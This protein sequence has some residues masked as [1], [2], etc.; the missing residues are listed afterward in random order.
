MPKKVANTFTGRAVRLNDTFL[1]EPSEWNGIF[2]SSAAPD[3]PFQACVCYSPTEGISLDYVIEGSSNLPPSSCLHGV[4]NTGATCT[5]FGNFPPKTPGLQ[6]GIGGKST[7]YGRTFAQAVLIGPAV[8]ENDAFDTA[9]FSLTGQ[10]EFF[11]P[12]RFVDEEQYS[13]EP[14]YQC[15][16]EFGKLVV[17]KSAS[18]SFFAAKLSSVIHSFDATA[19]SDLDQAFSD[20]RA[21]H[22]DSHFSLKKDLMYVVELQFS[23][24]S[25]WKDCYAYVEQVADLLSLLLYR[26]VVPE[27]IRLHQSANDPRNSRS[28]ELYAGVL[29]RADALEIASQ[30]LH[31]YSMPIR[32]DKIP[33]EAILRRWFK[34]STQYRDVVQS[35]QQMTVL[36][37][38]Q[39]TYGDLILFCVYFENISHLRGRTKDKYSYPIRAFASKKLRT[40]I[41]AL[42][43]VTT[44][45]KAG[46]AISDLRNEVAHI[47]RPK[48][49]ISAM[50][51]KHLGQLI[52]AMHLVN[53]GYCLRELGAHTA[54]IHAMQDERIPPT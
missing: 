39:S 8:H 43:A 28:W 53:V 12:T 38:L 37:S 34:T 44:L 32:A 9:T 17:R 36:Q 30:D 7:Q 14:V 1:S 46:A 6:V 48:T 20:V 49:R 10:Q 33:F 52:G 15:R 26:P 5:I 19:N 2:R 29:R 4:L 25:H 16:T 3:I 11:F 22:P 23:R 24:R 13:S 50:T 42:L 51:N 35:V 45:K 54:A 27:W 18:F 47:G 21:R 40:A 31:H 41:K